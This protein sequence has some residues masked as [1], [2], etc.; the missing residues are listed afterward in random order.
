M[1]EPHDLAARSNQLAAFSEWLDNSPNYAGLDQEAHDW[2]RIAKVVEESGEAFTAFTGTLGENP[3]K[4]VT[5]TLEDVKKELF[6][7]AFSALG[8]VEHLNGNKGGT[9]EAFLGHVD[10]VHTR[11]LGEPEVEDEWEDDLEA[12]HYSGEALEA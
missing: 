11:A 9:L 2:R 6:D 1:T 8:A 4:G 3:R 7:V 5:H 10:Y 12:T